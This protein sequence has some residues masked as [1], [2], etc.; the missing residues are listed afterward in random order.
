MHPAK[1]PHGITP[2]CYE[3]LKGMYATGRRVDGRGLIVASQIVPVV[4]N[5]IDKKKLRLCTNYKRTLNDH[6][7]HKPYPFLLV[8]SN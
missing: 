3:K 4:K 7:E 2:E 5:K 8:M 6:I 1:V